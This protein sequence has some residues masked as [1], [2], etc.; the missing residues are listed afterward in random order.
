MHTAGRRGTGIQSYF[1]VVAD[2]AN[3]TAAA[4][5]VH[6]VGTCAS[7][8]AGTG[9]TLVQIYLTV[10]ALREL[11]KKMIPGNIVKFSHTV[12]TCHAYNNL[13]F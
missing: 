13:K 3:F 5:S 6:S 11:K 1:T 9:A 12:I 2:E 7:I 4:K 10:T 8:V